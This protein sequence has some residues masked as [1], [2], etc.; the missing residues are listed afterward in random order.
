MPKFFP[1]EKAAYAGEKQGLTNVKFKR[2]DFENSRGADEGALLEII[3]VHIKN[4]PVIQFMAF[5]KS[6]SDNF[7]SQYT[8]EQPFGRTDP[9]YIWKSSKR[10]ITLNLEIPSSGKSKALDNLNNLNWL[11]ASLYPAYKEG[12]SASSISASPL[13]RVR[14]SNL[15]ASRTQDGQGLL[16]VIKTAGVT[17]DQQKGHIFVQPRN[18]SSSTA[19]IDASIIKEAGFQNST[20]EGETIQIPK[21]MSLNLT[22]DVVHDHMLGWDHSTGE[23]RAGKTAGKY[24]YGFGLQR[25]TDPVPAG[26][27]G[28]ATPGTPDA[29]AAEGF[30]DKLG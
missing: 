29:R 2:N 18:M 12:D 22:L 20:S 15:I 5:L 11:L 9:Y 4:P 27:A 21:L 17:H 24:P 3:P 25:E 13:F 23:W 30:G 14:Y 26:T 28:S 1:Y 16:C 10:N 19:N 8:E 6:I 7:N